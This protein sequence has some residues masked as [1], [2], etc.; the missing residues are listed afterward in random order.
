MNIKIAMEMICPS[1]CTSQKSPVLSLRCKKISRINSIW[2]TRLST[3][4]SVK[5]KMN[6]F[7]ISDPSPLGFSL[8]KWMFGVNMHLYEWPNVHVNAAWIISAVLTRTSFCMGTFAHAFSLAATRPLSRC[9]P[10]MGG[11]RQFVASILSEPPQASLV[12]L[13]IW[14]KIKNRFQGLTAQ[15]AASYT[16]IV[17]QPTQLKHYVDSTHCSLP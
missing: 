14:N 16:S 1:V 13:T 12:W 11:I 10:I 3:S 5:R 9:C 6:L 17:R 2:A 15:R 4:K 8:V 7:L